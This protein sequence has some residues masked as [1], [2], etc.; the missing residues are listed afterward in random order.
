MT[1]DDFRQAALALPGASEGSHANHPD[2]RVNAKVFAS[3]GYPDAAWG[4]VM[5]TREE[6]QAFTETYPATFIPIN[7]SWGSKGATW[8][9]LAT[10]DPVAVDEAL[11]AAWRTKSAPPPAKKARKRAQ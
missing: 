9:K 7:N 6:Q 10:A 4:V 8:V 5:L 3:L 2:F 1:P 11:T